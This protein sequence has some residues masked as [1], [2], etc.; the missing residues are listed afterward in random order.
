MTNMI[1]VGDIVEENGKTWRENNLAKKHTFSMH[2]LVE[3]KTDKWLGHNGGSIKIH[4]RLWISGLSRDCDGTPQYYLTDRKDVELEFRPGK[5]AALQDIFM[6]VPK[7]LQNYINEGGG[8]SKKE[9]PWHE[10][11]KIMQFNLYGPFGADSLK[12][13]DL[14]EDIISGKDTLSWPDKKI[15]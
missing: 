5:A 6:K 14:T 10:G 12:V 13:V 15:Q 3:V 8:T 11:W 7:W 1:P 2:Q 4:G 9:L